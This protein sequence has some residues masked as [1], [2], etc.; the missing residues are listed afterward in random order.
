M[1]GQRL[2]DRAAP[3][4]R[5]AGRGEVRDRGGATGAER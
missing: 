1:G 5:G 3:E 4:L 2:A